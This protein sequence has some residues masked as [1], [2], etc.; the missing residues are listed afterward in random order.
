MIYPDI[1]TNW[2]DY[3]TL[4]KLGAV[5][6]P[7]R[8]TRYA[9]H[10]ELFEVWGCDSYARAHFGQAIWF[11]RHFSWTWLAWCSKPRTTFRSTCRAKYSEPSRTCRWCC[12]CGWD[13]V[14]Y[15]RCHWFS[16]VWSWFG[17][18]HFVYSMSETYQKTCTKK[19]IGIWSRWN[20]EATWFKQPVPINWSEPTLCK[21][22]WWHTRRCWVW[23]Y[24]TYHR[25]WKQK[26]NQFL[27]NWTRSS[28]RSWKRTS[29][30]WWRSW[31]WFWNL[32]IP[33]LILLSILCYIYL[34]KMYHV[35]GY[36]RFM[37]P[38]KKFWTGNQRIWNE[39]DCESY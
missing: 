12:W 26:L 31:C 2:L 11:E 22:L 10:Y 30:I 13:T 5:K 21:G 24:W 8:A 15:Q 34:G 38:Q 9:D 20:T 37:A 25:I 4:L 39:L 28:W 17:R 27:F 32:Q 1:N 3:Q 23:W 33:T 16:A 14:K 36:L 6:H 29:P 19:I 7:R 18:L 35:K